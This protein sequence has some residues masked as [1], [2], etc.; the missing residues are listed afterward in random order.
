MKSLHPEQLLQPTAIIAYNSE[1]S[2]EGDGS[3]LEKLLFFCLG[4]TTTPYAAAE[5]W[6]GK[7][8]TAINMGPWYVCKS[9]LLEEK[10]LEELKK[11]LKGFSSAAQLDQYLEE[12]FKKLMGGQVQQTPPQTGKPSDKSSTAY[13]Q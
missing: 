4:R 6:E 11:M 12:E 1:S 9:E 7:K 2:G 3:F 13:I 8:R 5:R 10:L